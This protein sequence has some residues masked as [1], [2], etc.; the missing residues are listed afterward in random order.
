ME[1]IIDLLLFIILGILIVAV[2][3]GCI[4][5]FFFL[6]N[7]FVNGKILLGIL[8]GGMTIGVLLFLLDIT[9]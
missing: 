7:L 4:A 6:V 2:V 9:S 5:L 8:I 3:A 1:I